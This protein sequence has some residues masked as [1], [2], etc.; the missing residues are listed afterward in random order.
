MGIVIDVFTWLVIE[1]I[2]GFILYATGCLVLKVITFGQYE[3]EF[4]DYA[5]FKSSKVHKVDLVWLLGLTFYIS[6]I[7]LIAYAI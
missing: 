5:S 3:M 4:K 6:L 2:L 7:L 1:T